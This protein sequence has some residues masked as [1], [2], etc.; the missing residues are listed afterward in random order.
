MIR[1]SIM[2]LFEKLEKLQEPE[3]FLVVYILEKEL[4]FY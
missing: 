4:I 3:K 2:N 1:V